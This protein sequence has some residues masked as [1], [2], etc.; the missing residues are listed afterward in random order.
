MKD[1]RDSEKS[2]ANALPGVF[3]AHGIKLSVISQPDSQRQGPDLW[4]NLEL[5]DHRIRV[6]VEIKARWSQATMDQM[7]ALKR[8]ADNAPLLLIMP[9]IAPQLHAMLRDK[10]V[11][12]AD[13][14]GTL[15]LHAPGI[16]IDVQERLASSAVYQPVVKR[17]VN[18]FS[19]R[20]SMVLR[21][22][23]ERPAEHLRFGEL[24]AQTGLA[25]G[26]VSGVVD[27]IVHRGYA[28][29]SA[30]GVRLADPAT[31]LRDWL[32]AYAWTRNER[33]SYVVPY[34]PDEVPRR[35]A[36]FVHKPKVDWALTLLSAAQRLVGHV[37]AEG[38]VH[39]YVRAEEAVLQHALKQLFAEPSVGEGG[40]SILT[41]YYGRAAFYGEQDLNGTAAVSD[42]QLFLDLAH[43]PV[44]GVEAAEM[45][46][47]T[48]LAPKLQMKASD[49]HR[50]LG[51]IS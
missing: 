19:K 47:R 51:D 25:A 43:F 38:P 46:L 41:P 5:D 4:C 33:K 20:A 27:E 40:L 12:H 13:L 29:R 23:F 39:V 45:L 37:Q 26:W 6:A 11:N 9:R 22:L 49:L 14:V 7:D 44:R 16:R 24:A 50:L 42:L 36:M 17:T 2:I 28:E 31:A 34:A 21:V 3:A 18:P 10:K 1:Q 8:A 48:R 32:V 15:Y 35:L 30:Q